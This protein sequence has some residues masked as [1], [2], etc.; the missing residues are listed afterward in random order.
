MSLAMAAGVLAA[1]AAWAETPSRPLFPAQSAP[2]SKAPESGSQGAKPLDPKAPDAGRGHRDKPKPDRAAVPRPSSVKTLAQKTKVLADLHERLVAAESAE[3]AEVVADTIEQMWLYSGSD[4]TNLLMERAMKSLHGKQ[5]E[6]A[7]KILD[8]VV[9]LKPNFAEGWNRRAYVHFS[10]KDY[11]RALIDLRR[12]LAIEPR[13][14]KAI[15]G[16]ATILREFGDKRGALK[17]YRRHPAG[18]RK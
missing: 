17:A 14:F 4:T 11:R 2:H 6:L 8:G 12:V 18:N 1:G 15:N 16:L 9:A 5:P 7:L 3:A 10:Q 13:H